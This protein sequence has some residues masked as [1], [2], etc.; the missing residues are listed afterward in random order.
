MH[1]ESLA[2]KSNYSLINILKSAGKSILDIYATDFSV[3]QKDDMSP[4]TLADKQSHEILADYLQ[5]HY[6]FPVLSEEGRNIPYPERQQWKNFW[7]V[8]PLDGTKEFV[9]KNGEFT[10]NVAL[11][12]EG[13][14]VIGI[15]Y[16]PLTDTLYYA[17]TGQ[18]AYKVKDG[19]TERL[20][21]VHRSG[22]LTV[23]GSRS[24]A[25]KEFDAFV[26]TIQEK[27]GEVD[28]VSAGSALKFCLVAEGLADMYPRL[29]PTMEWDTAA[30]QVIVEEAGG[31]VVEAEG[32]RPLRYNKELLTNPNFIVLRGKGHGQPGNN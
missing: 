18:G 15:I 16:V 17:S 23:V 19:K 1:T 20:P 29:G 28:V 24:H 21:L 2:I 9:K 4:L 12:H 31:S 3:F 5:K 11:V 7:L 32:G 22:K 6:P 27:H 26:R 25:S 13:K 8:D 14:P 10:I 30:G